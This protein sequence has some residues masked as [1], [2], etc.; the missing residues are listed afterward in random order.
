MTRRCAWCGRY[1]A[2]GVPALR[3]RNRSGEQLV[4]LHCPGCRE[5]AAA[6]AAATERYLSDELRRAVL[7]ATSDAV[8]AKAREAVAAGAASRDELHPEVWWVR[9]SAGQRYRVALSAGAGAAD[10]SCPHGG[11]APGL[12]GCYHVAAAVLSAGAAP[13]QRSAAPA[14]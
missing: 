12:G 14:V 10:C 6:M 2:A 11:Y 13:S 4:Q 7:E 8:L 9:G 5:A 1:V 3:F